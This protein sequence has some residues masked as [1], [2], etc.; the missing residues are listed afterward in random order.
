MKKL[1]FVLTAFLLF[2]L[3]PATALMA[4]SFEDRVCFRG[5]QASFNTRYDVKIKDGDIW[6]KERTGVNTPEPRVKLDLPDG[7][8]GEVTELAMDD[9]HIIALNGERQIYTMWKGLDDVSDFTWQ[10]EWGIPFWMGPGMK[11]TDEILTWDFSV[12]SR[13]ED[14]FWT[15]PAGNLFEVGLAKCS[16]IWMLG[17]N[18]QDLIYNDPWLPTDYSYGICGPERGAFQAVN[19][20]TSGSHLFLINK[21]G[22]MYTRFYD[23]DIGGA[24]AFLPSSYEDQRDK[25]I[26][27][28]QI[29]TDWIRHPKISGTITDRIS[30]H[31]IGRNCIHRTLRVEGSNDE[32]VTGYFEKDIT[33]VDDTSQ[34]TF[35]PTGMPLSGK[36]LDNREGDTTHLTLG[37]RDDRYYAK[38]MDNLGSLTPGLPW[39]HIINAGDWAAELTNFSCYNTPVDLVVHLSPEES[40][41]LKLHT[42]ETIRVSPRPRGLTDEA[43]YIPGAIE[44]PKA[45]LDGFSELPVK[46][47]KF[48]ASYLMKREFTRVDIQ[49]T[50]DK[51]TVTGTAG[52]LLIVW[53]FR[54]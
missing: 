41:T 2:S 19:L 5:N 21:Y 37:D 20:S 30:I 50:L 39:Y 53:T 49:A 46:S 15:D 33:E 18:G 40:I 51:V 4:E 17:P 16:H 27:L 43:R 44:V 13:R 47:R 29:P 22:D 1:S 28:I 32:G 31:K 6:I 10:K 35:H 7:L 42:K 14:G 12:V 24:D 48:I 52:G 45:L 25:L 11:L 9:E 3:I 34:W 23:F 8:A 26:P 54:H 38:N 36:V